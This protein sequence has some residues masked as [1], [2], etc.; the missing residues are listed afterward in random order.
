MFFT[1]NF[2]QV[3]VQRKQD[4]KAFSL[5]FCMYW[6]VVGIG[7][8]SFAKR[9]SSREQEMLGISKWVTEHCLG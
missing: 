5:T 3:C 1:N 7:I 9:K 2:D 4:K 8:L 6:V